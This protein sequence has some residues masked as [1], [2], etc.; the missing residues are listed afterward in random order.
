MIATS[1]FT[2]AA[3]VIHTT[4]PQGSIHLRFGNL[5]QKSCL[6][7]NDIHDRRFCIVRILHRIPLQAEPIAI[8]LHRTG[9]QCH[10]IDFISTSIDLVLVAAAVLPK[11]LLPSVHACPSVPDWRNPRHCMARPSNK[12]FRGAISQGLVWPGCAIRTLAGG[13]VHFG[14]L[15]VGQFRPDGLSRLEIISGPHSGYGLRGI[16][17]AC[18][19]HR[20]CAAHLTF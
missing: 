11:I 19:V 15:H 16:C 18:V 13:C 3:V 9:G 5:V 2:I 14:E 20:V 1:A 7:N 6:H 8:R 4:L 12:G 17:K 10:P